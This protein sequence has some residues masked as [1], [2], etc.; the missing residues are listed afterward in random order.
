MAL[1][2]TPIGKDGTPQME[3]TKTVDST[4]TKTAIEAGEERLAGHR[5]ANGEFV[6]APGDKGH[7]GQEAP[8]EKSPEQIQHDVNSQERAIVEL[9]PYG[10]LPDVWTMKDVAAHMDVM[11][12]HILVEHV[13]P[14][15]KTKGG[16]IL[17]PNAAVRENLENQLYHVIKAGPGRIKNH[18][19]G[20]R[21]KM[22]VK[23]GDLVVLRLTAAVKFCQ[24]KRDYFIA[25]DDD[26]VAVLHDVE[27]RIDNE[28]VK[29]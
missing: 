21:I 7:D 22:R 27:V 26:V 17:P 11:D 24:Q 8:V 10:I 5:D 20:D 12:N 3:K 29:D 16:I 18:E 23:D 14:P 6:P 28:E 13:A 19:S 9:E 4:P 1:K 25:R 15:N 2:R